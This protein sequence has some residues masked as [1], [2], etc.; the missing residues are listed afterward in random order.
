[1]KVLSNRSFAIAGRIVC[2]LLILQVGYAG[3]AQPQAV[4]AGT[5]MGSLHSTG[6]V[7]INGLR[8][9]EEQT[10]LPGDVVS[11]GRDGAVVVTVPGAGMLSVGAETEIT[12]G[13]DQYFATLKQG[14]VAIHSLQGASNL[15][16]RFGNF[17]LY[18]PSPGA[19]AVATLTVGADGAQVDCRSG[20]VG[21]TAIQGASAVILNAGESATVTTPGDLRKVAAA[22]VPITPSAP[23]TPA[24]SGKARTGYIILGV[25]AAGGGIGAAVA[26]LARPN[27]SA[28]VNHRHKAKPE[29]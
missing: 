25:A 23:T 8:G 3:A 29:P 24:P 27:P 13:I 11:T 14:T 28:L 10:V 1:M 18:L 12:F 26:L 6:E 5:G 16:V 19:E 22:P 20:V 9:P 7:N 4:P 15:D 17:L 2:C 21:V